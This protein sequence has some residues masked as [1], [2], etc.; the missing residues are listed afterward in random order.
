MYD[1]GEGVT[2]DDKE[3]VKWLR[4]AAEQGHASSQ[5]NLG[6]MYVQG[7]AVIEDYIQAYAWLNIAAANGNE[8]AKGAKAGLAELMTQEQ[9]AEAQQLSTE[10]VE[11][12]PKLIN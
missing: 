2:E 5:Y 9:I 3:A 12:N 10:M 8:N 11:A 4:K 7:E 1:N 6:R